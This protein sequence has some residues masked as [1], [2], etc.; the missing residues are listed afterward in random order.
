MKKKKAQKKA[1]KSISKPASN[2]A[3]KSGVMPLGDKV[4]IK[5]MTAEEM[6]TTTSF[7]IIIPETV[8]KEKSDRGVVVAV[9]AGKRNERGERVSPEVKVGDK[10][11][12]TKP[13][14]EPV[15]IAGV[16]Y[17]LVSESEILAVLN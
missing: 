1:K 6:S 13:W 11:L 16:E 5:P 10:V 14:N 8:S 7:G 4:L 3:N 17:Y 15:K 12:Y 9:G 2:A